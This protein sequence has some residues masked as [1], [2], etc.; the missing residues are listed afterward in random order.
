MNIPTNIRLNHSGMALIMV[1]LMLAL[2]LVFMLAVYSMSDHEL[3]GANQYASS[4]QVRQFGDLA[5][6]VAIAQVRK[7]TTPSTKTDGRE[8]W[9]SQP[10]LIRQY[11][12]SGELLAGY[13]L[14]SSAQMVVPGGVD[15]EKKLLADT[16]P[17]NWPEL[18]ARYVDLNRPIYRVGS[19][20]DTT[21]HFPIIDPRAMTG[22]SDSVSGFSYSDKLA[23]GQTLAGVQTTG[24]DT[25]RLPMPVE[26][27]YVLSDGT[28]GALDA[29]N[30]FVGAVQPTQDNPIVGR[31]AFWADDET[32]KVNI[33]TASEPTP[34]AV[35]TFFHEEDAKFARYQPVNGELQ[36]Y[37]GHPATTALSPILFPGRT[38]TAAEK[39]LIYDLAPK[40][41]RG[42]T[43]SATVAYQ[44]KDI[45]QIK[46][47]QHRKE[48]LYASLDE[49]LLREDRTEN[50]FGLNVSA[51]EVLQRKGFFLTAHS[52]APELNLHGL[53]KIALWP[54]SYRG[55]D[56]GT[57]FDQLIAFCATLRQQDGGQRKY[58]FQRGNA[59]STTEDITR[60]ENLA[61]LEYLHALLE[62]PLPGFAA[63]PSQN[64]K[65]KYGDDLR[66]ILV[67]IFDYIRT[68]NLHDGNIV[69]D[70]KV[71]T[72]GVD[73]TQNFLLGYAGGSSR[74][75]QFKTFTDPRFFRSDPDN[76]EA[77]AQGL[78]EALGYP[79]HGQVTPSQWTVKGQTYQGIGRFPT[80]TEAGL[81]FI[82]A[83]D[84]TDDPDNT[85]PERYATLGKPGG[86]S[87]PT[88]DGTP[89]ARWY[90]NFPPLPSPNP[91]KNQ[92]ANL[93]L[94]PLTGGFPYGA[95]KTHPGYQRENWN[96]QLAANTPLK[97]GFRR[98]Q[99]RLL[100][101]FF[102]PAAGYTLIEPEFTVK[103]SGLSKFT[104]NGTP[105][106]P[107]DSEVLYSGRRATHVGAQM[108]GGH[109][110]GLKG[111][112]RGREA[113]AR[114]PMP[115]DVNWGD[116]EWKIKPAS[117]SSD[118]LSV[119]NYNL[120]SNF[121]DIDVGRNGTKPMQISQADLVI[122]IWSGHVGRTASNGGTAA[123][124]VQ[125]LKPSFPANTVQSPTL[126]R[127][128]IAASGAQPAV[129]PPSWWTFYS[130]GCMGFNNRD[131][132][133]TRSKLGPQA[134]ASPANVEKRKQVRGRYFNT[135]VQPRVGNEPRR[136]AIFY[137]FDAQDSVHRLFRPQRAAT[138]SEAEETEG[139]DVVQTV[140]IKHGDYRLTA[141]LPVVDADQ[142]EAHRH[143][144]KR[145]LA[146][147]FTSFVSN[148]LP[149]FDYGG[150]DDVTSRLVPTKKGETYP[151]QRIPDLPYLSSAITSAQA[152]GDFDNG[153]G[154]A[155]DGPYINKP[156]EGN[157]NAV[158]NG[159]A[160]FSEAGQH[161]T[162]DEVFFTPNRLVSSPV[163]LGSLPTGVKSGKP[164]RTLHF[165]PQQG[166]PGGPSKLGGVNPPDHLLLE[167]FWMPV[168][169]PYA[170]SEPLSTAGK[171]NLNYQILPFTHIRR[172]SGL[173]ALF[174]SERVT[175]VPTADAPNYKVF[176]NAGSTNEFWTT[177]G[178]KRWHHRIDAE[179]TLAQFDT[180][181]STGGAFL[182]PSEICDIHLVPRQEVESH[183]QM[184]AF[185]KER[186][187]TGDNTRERPYATLYPRLTTRSNSYR[188]H[189]IAQAIRKARSSPIATI[190]EADRFHGEHRG[191][192]VI[193][194]FLDPAQPDLPDFTTTV[195]A[196]NVSL[197]H[198][199]QFRVVEKRKFGN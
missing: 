93:T 2:M 178:G 174:A 130:R 180:R 92:K 66:Q 163:I 83:A 173:H 33:N 148:Q 128:A 100:L 81:H 89:Q 98:V 105:L 80:I 125:T 27:L 124:M 6:D 151:A 59:D 186:R 185:W 153:L 110:I 78:V 7:G 197:D 175:A 28:L 5:V 87:A 1:V 116:E 96:H 91:A 32:S 65:T 179:K 102:V 51:R 54:V 182:S 111:I 26:W 72:P 157:V 195:A 50:N 56:H 134:F 90:S 62:K 196:P 97:P 106:F 172:A 143:Y 40:I 75:F 41:G 131:E 39:N 21:L 118:E 139:S 161:T 114:A 147:N 37:P 155:R 84:N 112:L 154:P 123:M 140:T 165:R 16:P 53:P 135:S 187:L 184:D 113:P 170:I 94:W 127:N 95:D 193:E 64:F 109:G 141:A 9:T 85:F 199:Y 129:E 31:V 166:H 24:G 122:E 18:H 44:D 117:S 160:Y 38:L 4:Q 20:A 136:G 3:K 162:M 108:T 71:I 79:G 55:A 192:A 191:S 36:R 12:A 144:G 30:T 42:G 189:Y 104:L 167:Y 146:H 76:E 99:S 164:W 152:L 137:G 15:A 61:L 63:V 34:W 10:G 49:F 47:G 145:R 58:I 158:K 133:A 8:V 103:V 67:E 177:D 169:E 121:V 73:A 126:V 142:W 115:A 190:T 45:E 82:C 183:A 74:A 198:H 156:D 17:A 159:V 119:L 57:S 14:Y 69:Q 138:V 11:H 181:F 194:R 171:I 35:P 25:Q 149:G 29:E 43:S 13:K 120:L 150:N 52:R 77:N 132:I 176:P 23:N 48:R 88:L 188:V 46:L 168:V 22:G 70:P 107:R 60:P 68:T 101:E 19:S 86:R